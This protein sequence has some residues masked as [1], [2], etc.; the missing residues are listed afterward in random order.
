MTQVR[1]DH[2]EKDVAEHDEAIDDLDGAIGDMRV[3]LARIEAKQ[4][5]A[6]AW[7]QTHTQQ[8]RDEAGRTHAKLDA[9]QKAVAD[10]SAVEVE[11]VKARHEFRMTV[12]KGVF[13]V[14]GSAVAIA[15]AYYGI[16]GAGA[17]EG[18]HP[19]PPPIEGAP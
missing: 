16:S 4:A 5:A 18:D 17:D 19:P 13:G 7:Q 10:R 1:I 8:D 12:V 9:I 11:T 3:S 6:E 15:G 2:I 14:L